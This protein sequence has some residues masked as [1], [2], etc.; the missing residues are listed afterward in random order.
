MYV[1]VIVR[2]LLEQILLSETI[3]ESHIHEIGSTTDENHLATARIGRHLLTF[4]VP[5]D[6]PFIYVPSHDKLHAALDLL[7]FHNIMTKTNYSLN[8]QDD[9]L[10]IHIHAKHALT[11]MTSLCYGQN[12]RQRIEM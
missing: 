7:A 5:R 4:S 8:M 12:N 9:H 1:H 6:L 11:R 2:M 10:R 3:L